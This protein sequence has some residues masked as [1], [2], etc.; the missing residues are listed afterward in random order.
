MSSVIN[1]KIYLS[2]L[3]KSIAIF[4]REKLNI[5]EHSNDC[6][7][8]L[9]APSIEQ[10]DLCQ[11]YPNGFT[12][13]RL[14]QIL[15][16][17]LELEEKIESIWQHL[18][19]N[20][21]SSFPILRLQYDEVINHDSFNWFDDKLNNY[22]EICDLLSFE[23]REGMLKHLRNKY[24]LTF[25][26]TSGMIDIA[27]S[28][29]DIYNITNKS[30]INKNKGDITTTGGRII[31]SKKQ[32]KSIEKKKRETAKIPQDSLQINSEKSEIAEFKTVTSI[33]GSV[34]P[35]NDIPYNKNSSKMKVT[36]KKQTIVNTDNQSS[37]NKV[38]KSAGYS[39]ASSS[40]NLGLNYNIEYSRLSRTA[41]ASGI[42]RKIGLNNYDKEYNLSVRSGILNYKYT[43]GNALLEAQVLRR[44][45][46]Y[47]SKQ[48][49]TKQQLAIKKIRV[50]WII[51]YPRY[52]YI[53][54][55][56]LNSV[57]A[58]ILFEICDTAVVK[59]IIRKKRHLRHR[60]EHAARVIQQ[61]LRAWKKESLWLLKK[62]SQ[63]IR[64]SRLKRNISIWSFKI[65]IGLALWKYTKKWRKR[66]MK[67]NPYRRP[68]YYVNFMEKWFM[69]QKQSIVERKKIEITTEESENIDKKRHNYV[70]KANRAAIVI[71]KYVRRL[72]VKHKLKNQRYLMF[73]KKKI[74]RFM[75]STNISS[76]IR[77]KRNRI[78]AAILLQ[79]WSRG[80]IERMRL[81]RRFDAGIKIY[82]FFIKIKSHAS[83]RKSLR[84][85]ERPITIVLRGLR[86]IHDT[87][88][89]GTDGI[90]CKISI[91]WNPLLH[92]ISENDFQTIL[93]TKQP[94]LIY[95]SKSYPMTPLH[96]NAQS[97]TNPTSLPNIIQNSSTQAPSITNRLSISLFSSPSIKL[98][99]KSGN[100]GS[101]LNTVSSSI[102]KKNK[103]ICK[104]DEEVEKIKI[105]G[106]HCNCLIK[107]E[108]II[109]ERKIGAHVYYMSKE[110][111]LMF[112]N[113]NYS[114][115]M[116]SY[117]QRKA[118]LNGRSNTPDL[119]GSRKR[120]TKVENSEMPVFDYSIC[121]GPPMRSR[122]QWGRVKFHGSGPGK[123]SMQQKGLLISLLEKWVKF[124][125]SV[126][127]EALMLFDSKTTTQYFYKI[128]V[129][130]FKSIRVEQG[131]ATRNEDN[132]SKILLEDL[133]D[134][135]LV[136][137]HDVVYFRFFDTGSRVFWTETF[138][139]II[140]F[141]KKTSSGSIN[142]NNNTFLSGLGFKL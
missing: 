106:C 118:A 51:V 24:N 75:I 112:W 64:A 85:V 40:K 89:D 15:Q 81:F 10:T 8:I 19:K 4:F 61:A 141:N 77:N 54:K 16:Q 140:E 113:G 94:Q 31:S 26:P 41:S 5:N 100:S 21:L 43:V 1:D 124:Y 68:L 67:R 107:F 105:P 60:R 63:F 28:T 134:V 55:L 35:A 59:S 83:L 115:T 57:I 3:L 34:E 58:N 44:A 29:V 109:G 93:T 20:E 102:G 96:V 103:W 128:N 12:G 69:L 135:V 45:L 47:V 23:L 138:N 2:A 36:T 136:T 117:A 142:N 90:S 18:D 111:G 88:D 65:L 110:G 116:V 50:W 11:L 42:K 27:E 97:V 79:K 46:K 22:I 127:G 129:K 62:N 126:D 133:M 14:Y 80:F 30:T 73:M 52:K 104:F 123:R 70:S 139:A 33:D 87:F 66:F 48:G 76:R 78:A 6:M 32:L 25:E 86:N 122:C 137:T 74:S 120:E 125:I 91:W 114:R 92:I 99:H 119:L 98:I 53:R 82:K 84:R 56:S 7:L 132:T 49:G 130:E 108:F 38:I 101:N 121:T 95:T 9:L 131:V 72:I 13:E 71:Q 39:R 37:V 17:F